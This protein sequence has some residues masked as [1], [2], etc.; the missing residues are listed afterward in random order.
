MGRRM[1]QGVEMCVDQTTTISTYML[2]PGFME[3]AQRLKNLVPTFAAYYAVAAMASIKEYRVTVE[4]L[5]KM[6]FIPD[7]KTKPDH[8]VFT[9]SDEGHMKLALVSAM[10]QRACGTTVETP[11]LQTECQPGRLRP[12]CRPAV[13]RRQYSSCSV[14]VAGGIGQQW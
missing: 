13:G 1:P 2:D 10:L 3:D 9:P 7:R 4:M 8:T 6:S 5:T 14:H 12:G 11:L